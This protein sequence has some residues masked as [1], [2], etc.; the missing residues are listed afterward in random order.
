[1]IELHELKEVKSL[2]EE[3]TLTGV[4]VQDV[5]LSSIEDQILDDNIEVQ[6][7][8]FLGCI[9]RP[10]TVGLLIARGATVLASDRK[11][12]FRPFRGKLYTPETLF[13]GFD[14]KR[15]C[16]YCNT[17]DALSYQYWRETG[18][19][20]PKFV[21]D[22][23]MRS[24]HDLSM[25]DA[26]RGYLKAHSDK[27]VV[28]IMGGHSV[29]RN[30][31]AYRNVALIAKALAEKGYML[32]SGGGPGAME[33]TH[34][35]ALMANHNV[36]LLDSCIEI[37]SHAP[38]YKHKEWLARAFEALEQ[39]PK[40]YTPSLG[41]PTW[42]YGHEPPT[43]FATDIAKFFNN[44]LREEGL[45]TVAH[46]GIVFAP[47]SAGT[48][49][50]IFQD[51]AQ[52]HY[53]TTGKASPMVFFDKFYWQVEKPIYP[54]LQQLACGKTYGQLLTISDEPAEV[55]DFLLNNRA[56][57]VDSKGWVYCNEHCGCEMT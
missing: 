4:A 35:G 11:L 45:I 50:E 23:V 37:L 40:P 6:G 51:A 19:G 13:R 27:P 10:A 22:A 46:D 52:N 55:V 38:G 30:S 29:K 9:L 56:I 33:A 2:L 1:M 14:R 26:L 3:G 42:L 32:V 39:I 47:G 25:S 18:M 28:A 7:A 49:Q 15:P 5:D 17:P 43:P 21:G 57:E 31:S 48:I 8:L 36:A 41:I 16:T 34:L 24:I 20:E 44:S 54:I 53:T 12:P